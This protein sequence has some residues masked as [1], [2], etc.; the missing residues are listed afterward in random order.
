MRKSLF[1]SF[2]ILSLTLG[3][4]GK[5]SK[6]SGG[7]TN[8]PSEANLAITL[9]PPASSSQPPAPL[10]TFPLKV[11]ITST[12][13]SQGVT[14]VVSAKKDD[15]SP[16]PPFFTENRS[17]SNAVSDFNITN[18]PLSVVCLVTVTVTSKTKATNT[19]TGTYRYSRKP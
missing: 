11:T 4:A 16:D 17:T 13:P 9:D 14:I 12:M 3:M 18:T 5:C 6:G 19:F 1:Y 7:G 10:T 15:G 2:I 8:P